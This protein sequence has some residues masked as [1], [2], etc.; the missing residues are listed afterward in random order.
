MDVVNV[1]HW[2][3]PL[4][5]ITLVG[6]EDDG[7][8]KYAFWNIAI[9][10]RGE[11]SLPHIFLQR[12]KYFFVM[13]LFNALVLFSSLVRTIDAK[14]LRALLAPY[15]ATA[16]LG[17]PDPDVAAGNPMKGLITNP[18]WHSL[19]YNQDIP[20]SLEFYYI[21]VNEVLVADPDVVGIEQAFD[22]SALENDLQGS[23][24]RMKHG[25]PRFYLHYPGS[26][27][28]IP[29]Y[30]LDNG[31]EIQ[32]Y[33]GPDY[34][35]PLLLDAIQLFIEQFAEN[36]DGDQRIAFLQCGVLGK[37]G[38]W[39]GDFLTDEVKDTVAEWFVDAFAGTKLQ[40]RY[41]KNSLV[42]GVGYHDDSF[43]Y[44]TLDGEANGGV[45]KSWFFWPAA[46]SNGRTDF[47]KTGVMGGE[48]RPELQDEVFSPDYESGT[49]NKQDF[50]LCVETTHATYMLNSR[51][52]KTNGDGYFGQTLAKARTS[53]ARMGYNYYVSRVEAVESTSTAVDIRVEVTQ[54][55]VAPFYYP[56]SLDLDCDGVSKSVPGLN[57]LIQEGE[58]EFFVFSKVPA[59]SQCLEKVTLSLSSAKLYPGQVMKFAQSNGELT[60]EI[61]LPDNTPSTTS[62]S[63]TAS[64]SSPTVFP[65]KSPV[66]AP[67]VNAI[68]GFT[69]IDASSSGTDDNPVAEISQ[70]STFDLDSV[71]T[72]LSIRADTTGDN[73]DGV[74][75]TWSDND[76]NYSHTEGAEPWA[77]KG[78]AGSD[79]YPVDY[80]SSAGTKSVT[81]TAIDSAGDAIASL[82]VSFALSD[83]ETKV[84]T[85]SPTTMSPTKSPT[86]PTSGTFTRFTLIDASS[87]QPIGNISNGDVISLAST[88][89]LFNVDAETVDDSSSDV[90]DK[91]F[92]SFDGQLIR[93]EGSSPY[94]L[95]GNSGTNFFAFAPL[96]QI[97]NH[98][99]TAEA[100][101]ANDMVV[102]VMSVSFQITV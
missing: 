13:K 51:A 34:S 5:T 14:L 24:S 76:D 70:G 33:G 94:A 59:T 91:V 92:F 100:I 46:I 71:G 38:E 66:S 96:S 26:E 3:L 79:Y 54:I 74:T 17:S 32:N 81:A 78:N 39:N 102:D 50:D 40:F 90:I 87:D 36:Y 56:L 25:I 67:S 44:Y 98:I 4:S 52:F 83:G 6:S 41:P 85:Q 1:S 10:N 99:V 28:G 57:S 60:L 61:P 47:W 48:T 31:V 35:D 45:T 21:K 86:P 73:V 43:A 64:T 80:L 62:P 23:A 53:S 84:P 89:S 12:S 49:E 55:G 8:E 20:S 42:D 93:T 30:L 7:V 77:M 18:N 69:L 22:W 37:W 16:D 58:S 82:T 63:T 27:T 65:T 97:G 15:Y 29:Q 88:G 101:D 72:M 9:E 19:P 2:L 75:F 95:G 68:T 11:S